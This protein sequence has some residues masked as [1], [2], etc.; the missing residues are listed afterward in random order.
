MEVLELTVP[1]EGAGERLD[2]WISTQVEGVSRSAAQKF[3]EEGLVEAAGKALSKNYKLR[4]GEA[5]CLTIPDPVELDVTPEDIPLDIVYEDASL[6]VV[7]KPKGMVVHPAYGNLNHTLVNALLYHC[8]GQLSGIN[9][10]IRPGIVHRIDK[11]TSGLL[12][13]AKDD[14]A[15]SSLAAQIKEHSFDRFYHAV[16]YGNLKEDSGT[17]HQPIGRHPTDR[18]K[19]AVTDKN[20]RDAVT[21]FEVVERYQGFTHV[22]LKL[23]TGRTHQIRVHMAYI[24]HPVAGDPVYGPRKVISSLE[25]Q[26][27]HA[28]TISFLHPKTGELLSFDSPLPGYFTRFLSTLKRR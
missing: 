23:E 14:Q 7:N 27:L 11:D 26:C 3:C 24:G 20:S 9:G 2:K 13:V 10:V 22:R 5:L 28:K 18:K 17:V 21:H 19:M 16:V 1:P 6:L 12:V 25:G 4:G 15:H 8:K